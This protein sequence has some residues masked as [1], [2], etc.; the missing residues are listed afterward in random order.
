M[1][2]DW[3]PAHFP[4]DTHGLGQFDGTALYE[5]EDPKK[6]F[7]PDW[8]TYIYNYG[9]QEV[10]SFLLSNAVYWLEEFHVDGLRVDAVASM[11]YLDYSREKGEWIPNSDGGNENYE[12]SEM[13]RVINQRVADLNSG[14][15]VIAEES[16]A[17]PGVS[18]D[19]RAGGLGF[20]FKW[21]MGW[22]HDTLRYMS[23][24]PVHRPYHQND[25]TF[26]L[27]YAFSENFV[28]PLSHDEVVHGKGHC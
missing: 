15:M 23:V 19:V 11:L 8:N 22:M 25:L 9:R 14:A 16:T 12:A 27:N 21:N 17:W 13:L 5:H 6:G 4:T 18:R 2:Q 26:G 24:D 10:Q 3:V 1:L 28:L 20:S 7:H